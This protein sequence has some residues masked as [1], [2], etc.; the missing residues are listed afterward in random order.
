MNLGQLL[1]P[2]Q[3]LPEMQSSGH[4]EA[5]EEL[6]LHLESKDQLGVSSEDVLERL[7]AREREVSTG[8]GSGVAIPHAFLPDLEQVVTAFGRSREGI[9]FAAIDNAPVYFVVLFMVPKT[10]YHLHLRTLA[11][12]AKMFNSQ[13]IREE[14]QGANTEQHILEILSQRPART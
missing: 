5:I 10:E 6:V 12:I 2:D 13:S 7:Y 9:D 1:T 3:I 8:V 11:A 14:L 4:E